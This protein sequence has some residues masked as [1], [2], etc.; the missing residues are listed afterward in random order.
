[1]SEEK[2]K[3]NKK[4]RIGVIED[5]LRHADFR[6]GLIRYSLEKPP[7]PDFDLYVATSPFALN[8]EGRNLKSYDL[9]LLNPNMLQGLKLNLESIIKTSPTTQQI[10]LIEHRPGQAKERIVSDKTIPVV[11]YG[12]R[13]AIVKQY[14]RSYVDEKLAEISASEE[15]K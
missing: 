10:V 5:R 8:E 6:V 1:M 3:E 14:I 11:E 7:K 13:G 9:I 15:K 2:P 4:V 12:E